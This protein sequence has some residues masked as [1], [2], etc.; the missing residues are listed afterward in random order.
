MVAHAR[1]EVR[2]LDALGKHHLEHVPVRLLVVLGGQLAAEIAVPELEVAPRE[3][4]APLREG[5]QVRQLAEADARRDVG[6]VPLAARHLDLHAVLA[7]AH[8]PL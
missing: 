7:G 5:F 8:H 4:P 2:T 6:E 1:D 3:R